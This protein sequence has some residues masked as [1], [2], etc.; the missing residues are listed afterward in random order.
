MSHEPPP[1]PHGPSPD[2]AETARILSGLGG[3]PAP[4][5]DGIARASGTEVLASFFRRIRDMA[6]SGVA[7]GTDI[8]ALGRALGVLNDRILARAAHLSAFGAELS[9]RCFCLAVLGSEGRREQFFATDQ[10]NALLAAAGIETGGG[11]PTAAFAQAFIAALTAVGFPPCENRVMID[12]DDWRA[13]LPQWQERVDDVVREPDGPGILMLS[14]LADARPVYGDASLCQALSEHLRRRVAASPL[15]LG[16]M[17]REALRFTPPL[18]VFG[19]LT[20]VRDGPGKGGLDVKKGGLFPMVQGL[21]TLALEHGVAATGTLERLS[22]LA[23]QGVFS[24]SRAAG[25]AEAYA[26][27]QTLR[28]RS[29]ARALGRGRAADNLIFPESL[30]PAERDALKDALRQVT[31]FQEHL[32]TRY[33]LHLFP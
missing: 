6:L 30:T 29:Q 20:V 7:A 8:P 13:D 19:S 27:L 3:D 11:T 32:H 9:P 2:A 28:V 14:F 12:N 18:G 5:L 25:L 24:A 26:C 4:L 16:Y 33:G 17:A 21:R 23:G 15:T 1:F 10:D 31:D 22:A